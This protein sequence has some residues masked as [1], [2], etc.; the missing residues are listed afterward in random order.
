MP[1]REPHPDR[2][3]VF[4]ESPDESPHYGEHYAYDAGD[5]LNWANPNE[6]PPKVKGLRKNLS[7][8]KAFLA[9]KAI[10]KP[11]SRAGAE[12]TS[13]MAAQSVELHQREQHE[14]VL[15]LLAE[16]GPL[17]DFDLARLT[18][19]KQTS[20]GARRAELKTA[21]LVEAF[22]RGGVSDTGSVCVR[23]TLASPS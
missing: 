18:G 23:W 2:P 4:C 1:C 13:V 7:D 5:W 16:H 21:G 10:R 14:L 19:I 9:V 22:D 6:P 20:I 17:S 3:G 12:I 11:A 8:G 15:A